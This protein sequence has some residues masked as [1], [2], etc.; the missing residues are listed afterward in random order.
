[1]IRFG[2]VAAALLSLPCSTLR[3]E[4]GSAAWLRYAPIAKPE[5]YRAMP[6]RIVIGSDSEADRLA[7][8]ELQRG[9]SSMLGRPFT[10]VPFTRSVTAGRDAIVVG[11]MSEPQKMFILKL[12][13]EPVV[14]EQFRVAYEAEN[15]QQSLQ[16]TGGTPQSMLYG[17]FHLL[18]EVATQTPIPRDDLQTPATNLRWI[19]Q[20]DNLNGTIERGYAG[21]SIFF[22]AGHVRE[23]L[24]RVSAYGR[25]LASAGLNGCTVN[26][27]N[28]DL[29]TLQ[30]DM[31]KEFA[32]IAD[33]FRTW[34]SGFR[35]RS[36][37]RVRR[38]W[39]D[40]QLSTRWTP[41]SQRGG[42][43]RSMKFTS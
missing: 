38:S 18:R 36:I 1:M 24:S 28:S 13:A 29:R 27:V 8:N 41:R 26:N 9:L 21:R 34:G 19:N 7:A 37:F 10:V 25:L 2:I 35:C 23:D 5:M 31:L 30:P 22:D 14:G 33:A 20:W 39:A 43:R 16:I 40:C 17:V 3:A 15:G 11:S 12:N 42:R 32:R 6:S 4:D